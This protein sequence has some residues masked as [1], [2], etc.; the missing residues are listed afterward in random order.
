MAESARDKR[1]GF[2]QTLR[3]LSDKCWD[4][5][6]IRDDS[7]KEKVEKFAAELERSRY[8]DTA[9]RAELAQTVE[10][11]LAT[12]APAPAAAGAGAVADSGNAQASG[13]RVRGRSLL[14]S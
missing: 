13:F 3:A 1:K 14:F 8:L 2:V 9:Q 11:Y 4:V 12:F 10:A 6:A 7:G 5:V